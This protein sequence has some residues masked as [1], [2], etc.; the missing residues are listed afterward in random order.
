MK[1]SEIQ[2]SD[3]NV[4]MEK[5]DSILT[6]L[7]REAFYMTKDLRFLDEHEYR[8]L[9]LSNEKVTQDYV[10]VT[11]Q[12]PERFGCKVPAIGKAYEDE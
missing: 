1:Y 10:S 2:T 9:W 11:I 7:G 4:D 5:F 12:H 8:F 3:G 6:A